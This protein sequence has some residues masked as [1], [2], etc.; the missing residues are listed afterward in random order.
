[1]SAPTIAQAFPLSFPLV[2]RICA[3]AIGAWDYVWTIPYEI[4]LVASQKKLFPPSRSFLLFFLNRYIAIAT[5]V[6]S[7]VGYFKI[8][9]SPAECDRYHRLAPT[10]KILTDLSAQLIVAFRTYALARKAPW[11]KWALIV[12]LPI[13]SVV[14]LVVNTIYII[15]AQG[16]NG[17]MRCN[18]ANAPGYHLVW[19]NFLSSMVFDLFALIV[20]TGYLIANSPGRFHFGYFSRLMLEQGIVNFVVL[21][22]GNVLNV[23]CWNL[24]VPANQSA[25]ITMGLVLTWIM[26]QRILIDLNTFTENRGVPSLTAPFQAARG[27]IHSVNV[28]MKSYAGRPSPQAVSKIGMTTAGSFFDPELEMGVHVHVQVEDNNSGGLRY[29]DEKMGGSSSPL[30]EHPFGPRHM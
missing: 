12:L 18:S 19:L 27:Q 4:S 16:A 7:N 25:G 8:D 20:S 9:F 21:T 29:D 10:F 22:A 28:P 15:P 3:L 2:L 1:M 13:V 6:I 17:V 30:S 5:I 14:G 11:V 23:V 26:S 24:A